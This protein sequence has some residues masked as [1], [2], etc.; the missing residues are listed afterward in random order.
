MI[1]IPHFSHEFLN[2]DTET[3]VKR[4]RK[5]AEVTR[6]SKTQ[7]V[8]RADANKAPTTLSRD[9]LRSVPSFH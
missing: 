4:E 3:T 8:P 2:A 6:L 5:Y 1:K 7:D 9:S